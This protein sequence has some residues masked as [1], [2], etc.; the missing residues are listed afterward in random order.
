MSD[1]IINVQ[2]KF[3]VFLLATLSY[4]RFKIFYNMVESGGKPFSELESSLEYIIWYEVLT[5]WYSAHPNENLTIPTFL[6]EY[7]QVYDSR[8]G[9]NFAETPLYRIVRKV[10]LDELSQITDAY[11][12][13]LISRLKLEWSLRI[14][15]N[16][17]YNRD[18]LNSLRLLEI[19]NEAKSFVHESLS[20]RTQDSDL[21]AFP[22]GWETSHQSLDVRP[23]TVDFIDYYMDGGYVPGEC[24]LFL[25]AHGGGKSVLAVQIST[26]IGIRAYR[27]WRL[28]ECQGPKPY[29]IL[30]TYEESADDMRRRALACVA[31]IQY[32]RLLKI[33]F[34]EL[35]HRGGPF[36]DY[37]RF[38]SVNTG[39][40]DESQMYGEQ[41]RIRSAMELLN[42]CW[43]ILDFSGFS[44]NAAGN[45]YIHEIRS[46]IDRFILSK[47]SRGEEVA[48]ESVV[49]DYVLACARK[50]MTTAGQNYDKMRHL[51]NQ[52][53]IILKN[54]VLSPF[55]CSGWIFHQLDSRHQAWNPR[56]PILDHTGAAEGKAL[57][58]ACNF[59]FTL[60][61]MA[62]NVLAFSCTKARRA[63]KRLPTALHLD[64]FLRFNMDNRYVYSEDLNRIVEVNTYEDYSPLAN[65]GND[66]NMLQAA[67]DTFDVF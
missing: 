65:G 49:I 25:G 2:G 10:P 35:T 52:F 28:R 44:E 22:T 37:E 5:S 7:G 56:A 34:N 60:G 16:A 3:C 45:G 15:E 46:H 48:I 9:K 53:P 8:T 55:N 36:Q 33:P 47:R 4:E 40:T 14:V 57:G 38:V 62:N 64:N 11:Y 23:T 17:T 61:R 1:R 63:E 50:H 21:M 66:D 54:E 58:E 30:V 41:E 59:A 31:E 26:A 19:L 13:D 6:L 27:D 39:I 18:S 42:Q 43:Y 29:S 51:I 67:D 20:I 12:C 24:S 32:S